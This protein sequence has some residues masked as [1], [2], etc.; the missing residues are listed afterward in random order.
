MFKI[1][2]IDKTKELTTQEEVIITRTSIFNQRFEEFDLNL[3]YNLPEEIEQYIFEYLPD[4]KEQIRKYCTYVKY[5]K[6]CY[7][8]LQTF[9]GNE[10]NRY[11]HNED[12]FSMS[13]NKNLTITNYIKYNLHWPERYSKVRVYLSN[14]SEIVNEEKY[15]ILKKII[16]C[17]NVRSS[18]IKMKHQ[19]R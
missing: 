7:L 9:T 13:S 2:I 12:Y 15:K 4:I 11:F 14:I 1:S 3:L 16:I 19:C 6:K 17:S 5:Y 8:R 18:V 10:V